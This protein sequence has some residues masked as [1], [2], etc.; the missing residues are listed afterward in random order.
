MAAS[1]TH[2]SDAR[3]GAGQARGRCSILH[4]T[5]DSIRWQWWHIACTNLRTYET[6][7]D[8]SLHSGSSQPRST[9]RV[10]FRR[11]GLLLWL[12]SWTYRVVLGGPTDIYSI[13]ACRAQ[14]HLQQKVRGNYYKGGRSRIRLLLR[15]KSCDRM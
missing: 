15:H 10:R 5:Y 4:E 7:R 8:A 6:V 9:F 3:G 11:A 13:D 2:L 14:M 1:L 12:K